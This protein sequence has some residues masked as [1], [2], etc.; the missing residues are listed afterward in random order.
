M[1]VL[2]IKKIQFSFIQ[3]IAQTLLFQMK[4]DSLINSKN[5]KVTFQKDQ[6]SLTSGNLTQCT[7]ALFTT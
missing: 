3:E 2:A 4:R 1:L 5:W 7:T 6:A